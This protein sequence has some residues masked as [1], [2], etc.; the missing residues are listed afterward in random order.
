[1]KY[2]RR[3]GNKIFIMD[4]QETKT[5]HYICIGASPTN[6]DI[7]VSCGYLHVGSK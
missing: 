2:S 4:A 7:I 6:D 1:M 3:F 5:G